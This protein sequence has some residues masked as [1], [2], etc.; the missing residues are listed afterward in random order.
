[1]STIKIILIVLTNVII[2][3]LY[4]IGNIDMKRIIK[5]TSIL[6]S[7]TFRL[8]LGNNSS[9]HNNCEFN[10][11]PG[12]QRTRVGRSINNLGLCLNL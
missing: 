11:Q 10:V 9:P 3:N 12:K 8:L 2:I 6:L 4:P 5:L 7:T 1:M